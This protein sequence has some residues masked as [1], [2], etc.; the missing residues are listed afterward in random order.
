M[1]IKVTGR[2]ILAS[3]SPRRRELLT[4][5]GLAFEVAPSGIEEATREGD[6]PGEHVLRLAKQK[7]QAL[8]A[9]Y[10]DA[11]IMG[12]DTIVV[13]DEEILGK[14]GAASEAGEMLRRLSGREHQVYTG[15]ALARKETDLLEGDVARSSVF[16]K[17]ISEEEI[18]RYV[19]TE[20]PYDKAGGYALQGR[21][22]CFISKIYGS[23]TNVIGLPLC[24]VVSLMRRVG[25][26][27]FPGEN[28]VSGHRE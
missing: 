19:K 21:G 7:A 6:A 12:A 18:N 1:E 15:F 23:Y 3:A 26:I 11:W 8:S 13:L 2:L 10:P 17:N 16:F 28:N 4:L 25:A 20:E 24:E 9:H 22:A 14:P 27:I 5:M